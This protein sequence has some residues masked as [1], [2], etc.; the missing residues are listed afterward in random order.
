MGVWY[1]VKA[2]SKFAQGMGEI[3]YWCTTGTVLYCLGVH[4]KLNYLIVFAYS[5]ALTVW[6]KVMHINMVS[7]ERR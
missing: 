1:H 5:E 6:N 2:Q 4:L 3:W 7:K